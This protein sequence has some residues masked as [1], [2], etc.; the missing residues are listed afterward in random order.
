MD[1]VPLGLGRAG[2][3]AGWGGPRS[4]P[5][6]LGLCLLQDLVDRCQQSVREHCTF[7]HQ[8]LELRHWLAVLTQK[9][10]AHRGYLGPWD[11]QSRE[12]EAEVRWLFSPPGG[13]FPPCTPKSRSGGWCSPTG[14][15]RPP[16]LTP[17]CVCVSVCPSE[18]AGRAPREGGPAAPDRSP[19]AAGDG[20]VLSGGGR[21]GPG[22]AG[23]AGGVVGGPEAAGGKP[24]EVRRPL[25]SE[26]GPRQSPLPFPSRE[27]AVVPPEEMAGWGSAACQAW[28]Q[29]WCQVPPGISRQL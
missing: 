8:L 28:C 26:P 4:Q 6:P 18:T 10:E 11:A 17:Y 29:V 14:D 9:L 27:S 20:E 24:A 12:A 25:G 23:G 16:S 7:S 1:H 21:H 15:Q 5:G 3:S 19:R 2:G 13:R 22:G